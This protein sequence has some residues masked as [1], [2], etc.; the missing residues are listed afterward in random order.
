M[1]FEYDSEISQESTL[2]QQSTDMDIDMVFNTP[3]IRTETSRGNPAIVINKFIYVYKR[4]NKDKTVY[5][6]CKRQDCK[7]SVTTFDD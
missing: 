6:R 4:E 2:S 7:A 1:N 5:W 3:F